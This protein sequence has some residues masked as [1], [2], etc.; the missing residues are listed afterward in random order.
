MSNGPLWDHKMSLEKE[1]CLNSWWSNLLY[2]NNYV[3]TEYLVSDSCIL[4]SGVGNFS[5]DTL[6]TLNGFSNSLFVL[7]SCKFLSINP[8]DLRSNIQGVSVKI[9]K[10]NKGEFLG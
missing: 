10:N 9:K 4:F 1:R 8:Q 6:S 7:V 5:T 3:N 2:I